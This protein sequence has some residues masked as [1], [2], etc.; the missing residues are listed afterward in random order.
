MRSEEEVRDELKELEG[1][2]E[3]TDRLYEREYWN[4]LIE[5]IEVLEWVLN[6]D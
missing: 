3:C 1:V 5:K 4:R 2:L 6:E